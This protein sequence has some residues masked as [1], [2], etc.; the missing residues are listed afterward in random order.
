MYFI[1]VCHQITIDT[2]TKMLDMGV[3][4][5]V[6][7]YNNFYDADMV[8]KNNNCNIHESIYHYAIVEKIKEGIY[9]IVKNR[10]FYKYDK[11]NNGF[12]PVEEPVEFKNHTNIALG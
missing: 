11:N 7:Y 9:P 8:L 4:R 2:Q 12:F 3:S 10:W 1:T 6:G 5:V